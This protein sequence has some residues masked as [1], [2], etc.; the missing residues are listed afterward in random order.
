VTEAEIIEKTRLIMMDVLDLDDLHIDGHTT[1]ADVEEWDSLSHI[2][3]VVAIERAFSVKFSTG[4]IEGFKN[5]GDMAR[6]VKAKLE[7]R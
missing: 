7:A 2:R 5:V 1:A 6:A 4:E 3:L